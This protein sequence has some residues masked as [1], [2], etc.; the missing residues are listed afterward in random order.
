MK[1]MLILLLSLAAVVGLQAQT[2]IPYTQGFESS[3]MPSGW[4]HIGSGAAACQTSYPHTGTY[5][6]K[7]SGAT[8]DNVVKLPTFAQ[9]IANL[10][11]AFWSRPEG[12]SS[13]GN[14]DIGYLTNPASA[15]SFVAVETYNCATEGTTYQQHIA[16]F[17]GAPAG[18]VIALRHRSG[19]TAWYWFIDDVEV[20]AAS[21]CIAVGDL[22]LTS[23]DSTSATI[24]WSSDGSAWRV[25]FIDAAGDT[26]TSS[27]TDSNLQNPF[28]TPPMPF[29]SSNSCI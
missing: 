28:L 15:S 4:S 2:A 17:A 9:E 29:L 1:K 3:S 26:T 20:Y 6:L 13:S 8:S 27:T 7:F 10:E 5:S 11:I 14:F 24:N 21:T 12:T 22:R 18:S 25:D 19:S 23:I 16:T